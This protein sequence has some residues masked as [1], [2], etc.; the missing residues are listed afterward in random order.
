M[1]PDEFVALANSFCHDLHVSFGQAGDGR[2]QLNA[3]PLAAVE[4]RIISDYAIWCIDNKFTAVAEQNPFVDAIVAT[5]VELSRATIEKGIVHPQL[6]ATMCYADA[7][8]DILP[9]VVAKW[10]RVSEVAHVRQL[11]STL[12]GK[13]SGRLNVFSVLLQ[14]VVESTSH[15]KFRRRVVESML[16]PLVLACPP[17]PDEIRAAIVAAFDGPS[18]VSAQAE[19]SAASQ[20]ADYLLLGTTSAKDRLLTQVTEHLNRSTAPLKATQST[21]EATLFERFQRMGL[22]FVNI[23]QW[24]EQH[25]LHAYEQELFS[26]KEQLLQAFLRSTPPIQFDGAYVHSSDGAGLPSFLCG[27]GED[28]RASLV[29]RTLWH[30]LPFIFEQLD[31]QKAIDSIPLLVDGTAHI[32]TAPQALRAFVQYALLNDVELMDSYTSKPTM[33]G[34][35]EFEAHVTAM[36]GRRVLASSTLA[37][38]QCPMAMHT[39]ALLNRLPVRP[40]IRNRFVTLEKEAACLQ[41]SA[42]NGTFVALNSVVWP[43]AVIHSYGSS[44]EVKRAS[45]LQPWIP[46]PIRQ[47]FHLAEKAAA[48]GSQGPKVFH[49]DLAL[50]AFRVRYTIASPSLASATPSSCIEA[51][52]DGYQAVLLAGLLANDSKLMVG[53]TSP[54]QEWAKA[55]GLQDLKGPMLRRSLEGLVQAGLAFSQEKEGQVLCKLI[56]PTKEASIAAPTLQGW[57][58]PYWPGT[59]IQRSAA[60]RE[61]SG[62]V[63]TRAMVARAEANVVRALKKTKQGRSSLEELLATVKL[64]TASDPSMDNE[65]SRALL[66]QRALSSLE[67]KQYVRKRELSKV[68]HEQLLAEIVSKKE[69]DKKASEE[70]SNGEQQ[71][72]D[73]GPTITYW[74]YIP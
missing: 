56:T 8:A 27:R 17:S 58:S 35:E 69:H 31:R 59:G 40:I 55:A 22:L 38:L 9:D 51:I 12:E 23:M 52:V 5:F 4:E 66:I 61:R 71:I 74:E 30:W 2:S 28:E 11:V 19:C 1:S 57:R 6:A 41:V 54:L 29:P 70:R 46:A 24:V 32:P 42:T 14:A 34:I 48:A 72:E 18:S 63:I 36:V 13:P 21:A 16:K 47:V 53:Q 60:G 65:G 26:I 49:W 10:W 50:S 3:L 39:D 68:A 45:E 33:R 73:A 37:T 62:A 20:L 44:N 64:S 7:V 67:E 43:N 25:G 15:V